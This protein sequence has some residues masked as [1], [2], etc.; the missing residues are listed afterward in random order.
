MDTK[1]LER[2]IIRQLCETG[3]R[4][5]GR[6]KPSSTAGLGGR[7]AQFGNAEID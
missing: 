1:T 6:P 2:M 5:Q 7:A 3:Q 4:E